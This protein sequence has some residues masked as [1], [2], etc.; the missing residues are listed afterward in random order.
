MM[1]NPPLPIDEIEGRPIVVVERT[2]DG[3][4]VIDRNWILDLHGLHGAANVLDVV[5][6]GK[7][8]RMHADHHHS[9]LPVFLGPRT[10]IGQGA[11]PIDAGIGAEVD[12][13]D[14]S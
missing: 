11:Y 6:E 1:A 9:V 14:L 3:V 10:D 2:P 7:L 4:I 8:R 12:E 5:L 13:D